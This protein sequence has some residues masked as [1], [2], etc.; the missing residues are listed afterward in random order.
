L[1]VIISFTYAIDEAPRIEISNNLS[2]PPFEQFIGITNFIQISINCRA[3]L[4]VMAR[5]F[6]IK[7]LT[8]PNLAHFGT[9]TA[10]Y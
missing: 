4:S 2:R 1:Q 9:D 5:R 8:L 10:S 3:H 7:L 6:A